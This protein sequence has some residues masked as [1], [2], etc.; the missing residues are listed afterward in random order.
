MQLGDLYDHLMSTG[1]FTLILN[2]IFYL[3]S[4]NYE[5]DYSLYLDI[6]TT[7]S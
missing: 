5:S 3:G 2:K 7:L 1:I 4:K 6:L